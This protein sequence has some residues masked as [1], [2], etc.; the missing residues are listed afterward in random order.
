[1]NSTG[2][3]E[4]EKQTT[5]DKQRLAE[6]A[7]EK[8]ELAVCRRLKLEAKLSGGRFARRIAPK[9]PRLAEPIVMIDSGVTTAAPGGAPSHNRNLKLEVLGPTDFLVDPGL[10]NREPCRDLARHVESRPLA[11]A[12]RSPSVCMRWRHTRSRRRRRCSAIACS[13]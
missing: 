3:L 9:R 5:A 10:C 6:E 11:S 7:R 13:P 2:A 1:M 4:R 8:A 12:H